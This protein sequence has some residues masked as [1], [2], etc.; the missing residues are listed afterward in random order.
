MRSFLLP[1]YEPMTR[2]RAAVK[3]LDKLLLALKSSYWLVLTLEHQLASFERLV[4]NTGSPSFRRRYFE[5]IEHG[6]IFWVWDCTR[7]SL[8]YL[9]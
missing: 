3:S 5:N 4:V 6:I 8:R 1:G 9:E 2:T 7:P